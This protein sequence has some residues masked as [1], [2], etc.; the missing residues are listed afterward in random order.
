LRTAT[1]RQPQRVACGNDRLRN[2][3]TTID[4]AAD[5]G[6]RRHDSQVL[7]VAAKRCV[8]ERGFSNPQLDAAYEAAVADCFTADELGLAWG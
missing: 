3:Q 4:Q 8:G 1:Q 7:S 5:D 2:V 6:P